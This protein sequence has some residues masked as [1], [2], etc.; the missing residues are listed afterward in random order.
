LTALQS[1]PL[2]TIVLAIT[3]IT[4]FLTGLSYSLASLIE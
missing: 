1:L 4:T 3:A 2:F